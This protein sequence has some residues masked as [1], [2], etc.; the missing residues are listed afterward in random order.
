MMNYDEF[1]AACPEFQKTNPDIVQ[2]ALD[3]AAIRT[4]SSVFGN[5]TDEAHRL[6]ACHI[7]SVSPY[8]RDA[9]LPNDKKDSVY[10]TQR[11]MLEKTFCAGYGVL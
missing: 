10:W 3:Q 11:Q 9:R 8:G 6:L 5:K 2:M 7:L 1:R 4:D